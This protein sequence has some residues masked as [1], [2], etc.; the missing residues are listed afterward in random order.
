MLFLH[1]TN[2]FQ[3]LKTVSR[4]K[5]KRSALK[6]NMTGTGWRT[7]LIPVQRQADL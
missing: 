4:T 3:L 7:P 2:Y 5:I 1:Y 6:A